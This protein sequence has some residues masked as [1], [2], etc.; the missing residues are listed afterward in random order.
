VGD[1]GL[2]EEGRDASQH[3]SSCEEDEEESEAVKEDELKEQDNAKEPFAV[4]LQTIVHEEVEH[5]VGVDC[6][7]ANWEGEDV[8]EVVKVK[9]TTRGLMSNCEEGE[10]DDEE[11]DLV[12]EQ[13]VGHEGD[14]GKPCS[15][16]AWSPAGQQ[17]NHGR[18]TDWEKNFVLPAKSNNCLVAST[19][20]SAELAKLHQAKAENY[21]QE[22]FHILSRGREENAK[23]GESHKS[24]RDAY[25][26][27][28]RFLKGLRTP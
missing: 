24:G 2:T 1:Q 26:A 23:A 22:N 21:L 25:Q 19:S 7:E 20:Y 15:C 28:Q 4:A 27:G 12:A 14:Q 8:V 9:E 11:D 6:K 18:R 17:T 3:S 5:G 16:D 13:H 10:V